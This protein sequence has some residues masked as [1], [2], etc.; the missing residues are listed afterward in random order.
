MSFFEQIENFVASLRSLAAHWR[1]LLALAVLIAFGTLYLER[2]LTPAAPP[3]VTAAKPPS[4]PSAPI[5]TPKPPPEAP[6]A[7]TPSAPAD[8]SAPKDKGEAKPDAGAATPAES[9]ANQMVDVAARPVALLKG[10]AKWDDALKTL[11]EAVEKVTAAV[12]KAGLVANGRPLAVFTETD[13]NGF[14]FEAM[15]PL[16]KAPEGKPK[17]AD[18]VDIGA[19]PAGKA[20]KFQHRGAYDEIDTTY[21]AITAYL[22]EKGLD[23]KNLFIE[24]YLTD[25]KTGD[26]TNLEVDVY[27]FVK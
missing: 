12:G 16:A 17:L 15:V 22:D 14:H 24:E 27:V 4:G 8:T 26:E 3:A 6:P 18:G 9:I 23:T 1:V 21:E 20:L 11:S 25:L 19:S 2:K 7:P 5:E 13:D 10:Q